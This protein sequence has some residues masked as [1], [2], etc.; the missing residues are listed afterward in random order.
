MWPILV[1]TIPSLC[2]ALGQIR[3]LQEVGVP[4]H[5]GRI[6]QQASP[7]RWSRRRVHQVTESVW[8]SA[9]QMNSPYPPVCN[10]QTH[11]HNSIEI[12]LRGLHG[13]DEGSKP[14]ASGYKPRDSSLF[15]PLPSLECL[16]PPV[17]LT[18]SKMVSLF[19][20]KALRVAQALLIVAPGMC[21]VFP[22]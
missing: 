7:L 10:H 6:C 5:G 22:A 20:G 17:H 21:A 4:A 16:P 12:I 2:T 19:H 14:R 1:L 9:T 3:M 15:F 13:P 18:L 11:N 8:N